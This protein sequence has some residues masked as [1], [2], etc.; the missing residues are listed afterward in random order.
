L[1]TRVD[2]LGGVVSGLL[3]RSQ[4]SLLADLD[5]LRPT[6]DALR[7]RRAELL[8]T[9]RSLILLGKSVQR[10]APGD[11]LNISGTIQFL[12]NAPPARP[13]PGGVIHQGAEPTA[14]GPD[15]AVAALLTGGRR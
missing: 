8:P 14:A 11:Y 5:N 3:R 4:Q 9:F 10:A 1:L 12:L 7:A 15:A 6:L 2:D 13:Q